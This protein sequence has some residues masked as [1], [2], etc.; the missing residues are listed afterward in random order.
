MFSLLG[1]GVGCLSPHISSW[2]SLDFDL[3]FTKT[4]DENVSCETRL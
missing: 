1:D 2:V 4:E 3:V